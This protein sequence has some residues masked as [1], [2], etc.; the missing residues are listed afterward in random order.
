MSDVTTRERLLDEAEELFA[1]FGYEAVSVRSIAAAAEANVA[2][3][4]YHFGGKENLYLE[5]LR[6][7]LEPKRRRLLA[8]MEEIE[9]VPA[10]R[11]RLEMLVRSF[12]QAH[13]E[14][15]L[16]GPG[17]AMGMRLISRELAEPRQG[18]LV[19]LTDL[20]GPV[21]RRYLDLLSEELPELDADALQMLGG[22]I[23]GQTIFFAMYWH[24]LRPGDEVGALPSERSRTDF[25]RLAETLEE[26][27]PMVID[28]IVRITIGGLRSLR[29]GGRS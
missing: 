23:V 16:T 18:A 20:I 8:A 6:R 22:S 15:A 26:Y 21:R 1:R 4:N 24:N 10:G 29:E 25:P 5:V 19:L 14:D 11:P 13:L 27:I 2:A 9:S 17:G 3:V 12:V 28:H 7:R